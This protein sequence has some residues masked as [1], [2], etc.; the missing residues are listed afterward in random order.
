MKTVKLNIEL[1]PNSPGDVIE[2]QDRIANQF[3]LKGWADESEEAAKVEE[4]KPVKKQR[5]V[6]GKT[7]PKK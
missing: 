2:M 7:I 6:I 5:A 4:V 3:I 1:P